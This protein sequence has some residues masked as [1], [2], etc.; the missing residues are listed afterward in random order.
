MKSINNEHLIIAYNA[1]KPLNTDLLA[2]LSYNAF[3]NPHNSWIMPNIINYTCINI[4]NNSFTKPDQKKTL[5]NMMLW[6]IWLLFW[7]VYIYILD[8]TML[9][10]S[11]AQSS[12]KIESIS[13]LYNLTTTAYM[14]IFRGCVHLR[15]IIRKIPLLVLVSASLFLSMETKVGWVDSL[16]LGFS[17][18]SWFSLPSIDRH[19]LKKYKDN[20]EFQNFPR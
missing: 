3:F 12:M 13:M 9:I 1:F 5:Y 7:H 17:F 10:H 4:I 16:Y 15:F 8:D 6:L 18:V 2:C 11:E 20:C 14:H 19:A